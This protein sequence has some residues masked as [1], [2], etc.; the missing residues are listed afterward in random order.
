MGLAEVPSPKLNTK[1]AI[2]VPS[3]SQDREAST[4]TVNGAEPE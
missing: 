3:V 4:V 2:G 1:F